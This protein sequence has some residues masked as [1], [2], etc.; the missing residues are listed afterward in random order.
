MQTAKIY[1]KNNDISK[2]LRVLKKKMLAEGDLKKLREKEF[3]ISDG[4]RRRL[5]EKAGRKRWI[6]KRAKLEQ[7]AIKREQQYFNQRKKAARANQ[8]KRTVAK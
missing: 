6:K 8:S 7:Q 3:F 4:E 5:D 2:A 1:V